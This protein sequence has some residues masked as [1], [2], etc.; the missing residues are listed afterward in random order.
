MLFYTERLCSIKYHKQVLFWWTFTESS[1]LPI[2]PDPYMIL[3]QVH[4]SYKWYY[5]A[6]IVTIASV[7]GGVLGYV[8]GH[9]LFDIL[10]KSH[11]DLNI[12]N[13]IKS[14]FTEYGIW[15]I[16]VLGFT[17]IP[18]KLGTIGAGIF[19]ML[20]IPFVLASIIGRGLRFYLVAFLTE[21]YGIKTIN[22][23]KENEA[24]FWM[25]LSVLI[26]ILVIYK[27]VL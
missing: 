21:K 3:L 25:I 14:M 7:L 15:T 13:E 2:P 20:F 16:V 27:V 5:I 18:Y 12:F 19:G 22:L 26:A 9:Y 6:S 24:R 23:I 11:I 17:P 4:K 10:L 1:F 8:I